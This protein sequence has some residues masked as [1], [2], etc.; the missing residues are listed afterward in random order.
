MAIVRL[1]E[2]RF[3]FS[4]YS[5]GSGEKFI[6]ILYVTFYRSLSDNRMA[7]VRLAE[8][9][10][11]FPLYSLGSGETF[12][13][14]RDMVNRRNLGGPASTLVMGATTDDT[15]LSSRNPSPSLSSTVLSRG[16]SGYQNGGGGG[17][18]N[19]ALLYR[20]DRG[21]LLAANAGTVAAAAAVNSCSCVRPEEDLNG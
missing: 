21:G 5:L 9:R 1:A 16:P 2:I 15:L 20:E 17:L 6:K 8:I 19:P 13:R 12:Y 11:I 3:I 7:I 4:L 18:L 14:R 10:F